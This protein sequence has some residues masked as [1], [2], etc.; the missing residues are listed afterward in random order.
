[1]NYH[2]CEFKSNGHGSYD[3]EYTWKCTRVEASDWGSGGIDTDNCT[4]ESFE[5]HNMCLP[6]DQLFGGGQGVYGLA[7]Y[8]GVTVNYPDEYTC[9]QC[10]EQH[11]VK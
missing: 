5:S 11:N 8:P 7:E 6:V 4:H 2:Y 3:D 1:M 10:G 9:P